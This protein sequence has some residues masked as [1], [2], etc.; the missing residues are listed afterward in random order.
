MKCIDQ[1][2]AS[3]LQGK[4]VL[5]RSDFNVPLDTNGNVADVFRL[6]QGWKTVS[7]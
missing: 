2:P 7:T 5:L 6:Q 1:I 3:E 4:R